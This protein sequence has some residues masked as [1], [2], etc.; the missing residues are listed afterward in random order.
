MVALN[1][2]KTI[3]TRRTGV[4]IPLMATITQLS[5]MWGDT[6]VIYIKMKL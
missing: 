4:S 3:V 1:V 2:N 5:A 6:L